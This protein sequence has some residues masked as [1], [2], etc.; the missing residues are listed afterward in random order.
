M[1]AIIYIDSKPFFCYD[2]DPKPLGGLKNI[3][4]IELSRNIHLKVHSV[5]KKNNHV[6]FNCEFIHN[7]VLT[8]DLLFLTMYTK[9]SDK[10]TPILIGKQIRF[11]SGDVL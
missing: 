1:T 9:I 10:V 4:E 3:I 5:N 11:L 2:I 8:S 7:K 6:Y